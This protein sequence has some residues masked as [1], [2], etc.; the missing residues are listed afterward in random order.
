MQCNQSRVNLEK[1]FICKVDWHATYIDFWV[2]KIL[3]LQTTGGTSCRPRVSTNI[4][5]IPVMRTS[6]APAAFSPPLNEPPPPQAFPRYNIALRPVGRHQQPTVCATITGSSPPDHRH[7]RKLIRWAPILT[8][9]PKSMRH[10]TGVLLHLFPHR[11]TPPAHRIWPMP[12][13]HHGPVMARLVL[14]GP[15]RF[16]LVEQ[17]VFTFS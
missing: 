1:S 2:S 14:V 11:L 10:L 7:R 4:H 8:T 5:T 3:F 9:A 12:S 17:W 16:D 6:S 15:T 13:P